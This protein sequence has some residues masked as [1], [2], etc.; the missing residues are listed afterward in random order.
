MRGPQQRVGTQ[1]RADQDRGGRR[2]AGAAIVGGHRENSFFGKTP[3]GDN[4]AMAYDNSGR[5]H[6]E[7]DPE[8]GKFLPIG[9]PGHSPPRTRD[10]RSARPSKYPGHF[11]IR[12]PVS[13]RRALDLLAEQQQ[14]PGRRIV[15]NA[16]EPVLR[17]VLEAPAQLFDVPAHLPPSVQPARLARLAEQVPSGVPSAPPGSL[18]AWPSRQDRRSPRPFAGSLVDSGHSKR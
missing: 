6:G 1:A 11:T 3:S 12:M 13:W 8:T 16:L 2:D 17:P 4:P 18:G 15:L 7:R 9:G 14:V 10:D 5:W